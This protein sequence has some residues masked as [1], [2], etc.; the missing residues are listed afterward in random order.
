MVPGA[1]GYNRRSGREN[2]I[3]FYFTDTN[4]HH[5]QTFYDIFEYHLGF[6]DRMIGRPRS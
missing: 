5:P 3:H 4:D 2:E 1:T 6:Y